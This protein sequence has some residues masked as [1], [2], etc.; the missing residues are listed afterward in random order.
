MR[1]PH[2]RLPATLNCHLG[3]NYYIIIISSSSH[4]ISD[5]MVN[6]VSKIGFDTNTLKLTGGG[7]KEFIHFS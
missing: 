3:H 6:C 5:V 1:L 4:Q 2:L 7:K